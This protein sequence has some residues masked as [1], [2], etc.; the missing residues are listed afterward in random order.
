[1]LPTLPAVDGRTVAIDG[2]TDDE[3]VW[4]T[5]TVSSLAPGVYSIT[6]TSDTNVETPYGPFPPITIQ[7][8]QYASASLVP[9]TVWGVVNVRAV[10]W[11]TQSG[12]GAW[13]WVLRPDRNTKITTPIEYRDRVVSGTGQTVKHYAMSRLNLSIPDAPTDPAHYR[14]FNADTLKQITQVWI[15]VDNK[16]LF[17]P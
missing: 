8:C 3:L 5:V 1:M 4:Q 9:V 7:P 13:H 6:P 15:E 2:S 17:I 12:D 11:Q 10:A 16:S 14:V